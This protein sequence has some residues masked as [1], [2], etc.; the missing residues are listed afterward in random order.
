MST[1]SSANVLQAGLVKT[2]SRLTL[3][4]QT[5]VPMEASAVYLILSTSAPA[6]LSSQARLANK[7]LTSVL[8]SHL[9]ARTAVCA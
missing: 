3:V 4:P 2:A 5:L 8:S 7:M 1:H 6:R 9:P